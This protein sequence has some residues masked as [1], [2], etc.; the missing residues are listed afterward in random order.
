VKLGKLANGLIYYIRKNS[1]PEHKA[2]LRLVINAGSILERDNQ[3]GVAHFLI[4][5]I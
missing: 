1:K 2:E 4:H 5:G 3:Q